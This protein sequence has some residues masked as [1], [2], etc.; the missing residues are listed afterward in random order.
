M[1]ATKFHIHTFQN[2]DKFALQRVVRISSPKSTHKRLTEHLA[3]PQKAESLFP[4]CVWIV[5]VIPNST[6]SLHPQMACFVLGL[7]FDEQ[8]QLS[9]GNPMK[10]TYHWHSSGDPWCHRA[11]AW[12]FRGR[13]INKCCAAFLVSFYPNCCDHAR[14][15]GVPDCVE[16]EP[17]KMSYLMFLVDILKCVRLMIALLNV[18]LSPCLGGET[19]MNFSRASL[20]LHHFLFLWHSAFC[21]NQFF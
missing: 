5:F 9:S 12:P 16:K 11:L 15:T 6:H 7:P 18:V 10:T 17:R 1:S 4:Q 19:A 20:K 21:I 8:E 13:R 2:Y 3:T 14:V